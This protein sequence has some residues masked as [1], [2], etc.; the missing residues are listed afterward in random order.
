MELEELKKLQER[1]D[2]LTRTLES[3]SLSEPGNSDENR[4]TMMGEQPPKS[5]LQR[6]SKEG[7]MRGGAKVSKELLD[8]L[9]K[10]IDEQCVSRD[11]HTSIVDDLQ[12]ALTSVTVFKQQM[13]IF[14]KKIMSDQGHELAKVSTEGLL[15][16]RDVIFAIPG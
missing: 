4:D 9:E 16:R 7:K 15:N 8:Q 6:K 2:E 1:K 11:E 3:A 10:K 12:R 14:E 5:K 13:K